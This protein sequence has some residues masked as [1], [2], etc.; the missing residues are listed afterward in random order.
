MER[1]KEHFQTEKGVSG[2]L[3]KELAEIN[4]KIVETEKEINRAVKI[5]V[6]NLET[7]MKRPLFAKMVALSLKEKSP[8]EII[9]ALKKGD[10]NSVKPL[11]ESLKELTR[12]LSQ[13]ASTF[14]ENASKVEE[15]RSKLQSLDANLTVVAKNVENL[16]DEL[17]KTS[18][19][20]E[21]R[22]I[23]GIVKAASDLKASMVVEVKKNGQV[24]Q[25]YLPALLRE[26]FYNLAGAVEERKRLLQALE[27][28][29][30]VN[31][32]LNAVFPLLYG[33]LPEVKKQFQTLKWLLIL[34]TGLGS[35][36]TVLLTVILFKLP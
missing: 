29:E 36:I 34:L 4:D 14:Q 25:Y 6:K 26:M 30:D 19:A 35:V 2:E 28:L 3:L 20:V 23:N 7:L 32:K 9:E 11:V 22:L 18:E 1:E 8:D 10:E 24:R 16:T 12:E 13:T 21:E 17:K 27:R 31:Q 33:D 5:V 15:L